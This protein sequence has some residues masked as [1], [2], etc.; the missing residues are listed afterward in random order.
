MSIP[1]KTKR[2]LLKALLA[3]SEAEIVADMPII[4]SFSFE[5]QSPMNP[6][7]LVTIDFRAV[8]E[9]T[10][11][12]ELHKLFSEGTMGNAEYVIVRL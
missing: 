11:A 3:D 10:K 7:D 8:V 12:N 5:H 1:L 2:K 4:T 6:G 9:P